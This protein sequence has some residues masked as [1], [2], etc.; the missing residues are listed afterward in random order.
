MSATLY[1]VIHNSVDRSGECVAVLDIWPTDFD[2]RIYRNP[3]PKHLVRGESSVDSLPVGAQRQ[4]F[5]IV[6]P[7]MSAEQVDALAGQFET[8]MGANVHCPMLDELCGMVPIPGLR[9]MV[10]GLVAPCVVQYCAPAPVVH[11]CPTCGRAY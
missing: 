6:I 4:A 8:I 9:D 1:W 3:I 10:L 7:F 5:D 11:T 2:E